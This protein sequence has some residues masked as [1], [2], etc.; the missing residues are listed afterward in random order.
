MTA[1]QRPDVKSV[2]AGLRDFQRRTAETAFRRLYTDTDAVDRFL[3]ADEVGLGKTWVA[4]A[5]IAQAIEHMWSKVDRIDIIYVCSNA[6]IARQNIRRLT[7]EDAG[8]DFV[9]S[10]RLTL[11]PLVIKDLSRKKVNF[12]SL[13]PATSLDLR[14]SQGAWKERALLYW[15]LAEAWDIT[16]I[17]AKHLLRGQVSPDRWKDHLKRFRN[18]YDWSGPLK[19]ELVAAFLA[20]TELRDRYADL[21]E[22][23]HGGERDR[24]ADDRRTLVGELRRQL[25][26]DCLGTLEPDLVILDEF[27]RFKH[28]LATGSEEADIAESLFEYRSARSADERARILM[29]SATP[30]KMYTGASEQED[31]HADFLETVRFLLR[32]DVAKLDGFRQVLREFRDALADGNDSSGRVRAARERIEHVLRRVMCRTERLGVTV[33][34]NGMVKEVLADRL[35]LEADDVD[36]YAALDRIARATESGDAIEIWK[37]APLPLPLMDKQYALKRRMAEDLP[38]NQ[39]VR[40]PLAST[41]SAMIPVAAIEAY[42]PLRFAHAR[43]REL[44]RQTVESGAWQLLW[45]PP[46]LPYWQGTGPYSDP[47]LHAFTKRLLFSAWRVAPKA[48]AGVVSYEAERRMVASRSGAPSYRQLYDAVSPILRFAGGNDRLSGMSLMTLFYPSPSLAVLVDPL[49]IASELGAPPSADDMLARAEE[50]LCGL[51][52]PVIARAPASGVADQRWYW[53]AS[54]LLDR[55]RFAI[56]QDWLTR[57]GSAEDQEEWAWPALVGDDSNFARHITEVTAFLASPG[58][59]G[60]PPDDLMRVLAKV[61][62][63]SPAVA[64]L[65][66]L[67]RSSVDGMPSVEHLGAAAWVA[68]G[69]RTLFNVP[70]VQLHLRADDGE[71]YWHR[72]L[73]ECV[74]GN[75]QAVLDEYAHVVY[76]GLAGRKQAGEAYAMATEMEAAVALRTSKIEYDDLAAA[77]A[78]G[79]QPI[80]SGSIRCRFAV[81]FGDGKTHDDEDVRPA[82]VRGAFNSPFRPFVLASTSVGQEGLDFHSY[83]HAIVHWNLPSNPVDFE[84]RE[85][86]IHRYKG[87]FVRKNLAAHYGIAGTRPIGGFSSHDPWARLFQRAVTDRGDASDLVPFWLFEGEHMIE[88]HVP[89]LPLSRDAQRYTDLKAALALYRIV[90]GQPRQEDLLKLLSE[91]WSGDDAVETLL[92]HRIDLQPR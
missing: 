82:A 28:L 48:I 78:V 59:L 63:A 85:G 45:I 15:L 66:A 41:T 90:F 43:T 24:D 11:L 35:V 39:A 19:D 75:L 72:V 77:L 55:D 13:T 76:D 8:N 79:D 37:S 3:V 5:V 61:A 80:P 91:R 10:S 27:Q 22:R 4:R 73:D 67:L 26:K 54:L 56:V 86:R 81:R 65:R 6:D 42:Q 49:Q 7:T 69:F 71:R 38:T 57:A 21:A 33:D 23:H 40:Q 52:G 87:H 31:H 53:A 30:Y 1:H 68:L 88:R 25:A 14:G 34:R 92:S 47:S 60:R 9:E 51:L 17:G 36:A 58:A 64:S 44:L 29:L 16:H 2:L 50:R 18:D 32:D 46:S 20:R 70:E 83:C 74:A 62:I 84:Q 12:V 89:V